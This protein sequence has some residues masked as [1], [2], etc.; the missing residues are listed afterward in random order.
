MDVN[1]SFKPNPQKAL[2]NIYIELSGIP[3][4][5]WLGI[6]EARR[7]F[8]RHTMW[9]RAWIEGQY[10]VIYCVPDELETYHLND[11]REDVEYSNQEYRKYLKNLAEEE[12]REWNKKHDEASQLKD[13]RNR[14]FK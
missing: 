2:F 11:L 9:R 10:I 12:A 4:E 1:K 8:P 7:R 14:L 5:E 13:I 3:A 6:F